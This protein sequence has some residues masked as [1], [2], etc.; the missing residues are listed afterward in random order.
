M[1]W[2]NNNR[3]KKLKLTIDNTKQYILELEDT[4][5]L[6]IFDINYRNDNITKKINM[7]FEIM[8]I[9]PGKKYDDTCITS[10]YLSGGSNVQWGGR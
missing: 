10:I 7:K 3:V 2:K 4:K 8:E 9:Y 5:N 1:L 6:Q